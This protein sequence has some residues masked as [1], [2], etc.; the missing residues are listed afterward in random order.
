VLFSGQQKHVQKGKLPFVGGLFL[1]AIN[2]T[3]KKATCFILK[4]SALGVLNLSFV[5][6]Y[7]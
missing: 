2:T 4:N 6:G 7:C 5:W 1:Y 3:D